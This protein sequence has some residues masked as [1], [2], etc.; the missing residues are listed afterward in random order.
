[1]T[2]SFGISVLAPDD[3]DSLD[4]LLK[5]ADAGLYA[6]K[7]AGRNRVESGKNPSGGT[8]RRRLRA[9]CWRFPLACRSCRRFRPCSLPPPSP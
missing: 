7:K 2:G 1:V 6:A 8:N 3:S 5:R 9:A 4:E